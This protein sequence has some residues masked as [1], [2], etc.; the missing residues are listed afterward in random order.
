MARDQTSKLRKKVGGGGF[1]RVNASQRERERERE[2]EKK[3]K[4]KRKEMKKR[5]RK[6][7]EKS[8]M[9]KKPVRCERAGS[10]PPSPDKRYLGWN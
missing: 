1:S 10:P 7:E 5:E 3:K 8:E 9:W 4:T 2:R 6:R